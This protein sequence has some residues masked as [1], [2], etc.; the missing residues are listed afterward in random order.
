MRNRQ[1]ACACAVPSNRAQT[2]TTRSALLR[3]PRATQTAS[4][5][6]S[7]RPRRRR[8]GAPL[9]GGGVCRLR[10]GR[11]RV[12][13]RG[14]PERR[15]CRPSPAVAPVPAAGA[16]A[17]D[18]VDG[19]H[20]IGFRNFRPSGRTVRRMSG[21]GVCGMSTVASG[22]RSAGG[23]PL[24]RMGRMIAAATISTGAKQ[25]L[26]GRIHAG[27][28]I[29]VTIAVRSRRGGTP[30]MR[31]SSSGLQQA[32]VNTEPKASTWQ[33]SPRLPPPAPPQTPH[34]NGS[35]RSR[36][37]G[38]VRPDHR[39][40]HAASLVQAA[41][42]Q[43]ATRAAGATMPARSLSS[44]RKRPPRSGRRQAPT[45][46]P[47]PASPASCGR[48]PATARARCPALQAAGQRGTAN[49]RRGQ[50]NIPG[51][52]NVDRAARA[53]AAL[54][55]WHGAGSAMWPA[56]A[57]AAGYRNGRPTP[58]LT[59]QSKRPSRST[60]GADPQPAQ[61]RRFG[62]TPPTTRAAGRAC[63]LFRP[64]EARSGPL[65]MVKCT[66]V[67]MATSA[68]MMLT[69]SGGR[70]ARLRDRQVQ[71]SVGHTSRPP[72]CRIRTRSAPRRRG[73]HERAGRRQRSPYRWRA[74]PAR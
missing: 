59:C 74:R 21:S 62:R 13:A 6:P 56:A 55:H 1:V 72:G 48:Y 5:L 20:T 57:T 47:A 32:A 44:G 33:V 43:Q 53:L 3:H 25:A 65:A 49:R 14:P 68:S 19:S 28:Y 40:G 54:S 7:L 34:G 36:S 73:S 46:R 39:A 71:A 2:L 50:I 69:A 51:Q 41:R 70:R 22:W 23:S 45:S 52:R 4:P 61:Q 17:A 30:G 64:T 37:T 10:C 60:P 35:G 8:P 16:L 29:A 66:V 42:C 15:H 27:D 26:Q 24:S 11:L 31:G 12:A 9:V 58:P 38:D 67:T 18:H 63:R